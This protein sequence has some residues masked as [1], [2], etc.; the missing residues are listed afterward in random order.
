MIFNYLE[1]ER[2]HRT[3]PQSDTYQDEVRTLF[4]SGL[5]SDVKQRELHL[6]F[7]A[8][9]GKYNF[10]F[11]RINTVISLSVVLIHYPIRRLMLRDSSWN[12]PLAIASFF[13]VTRWNFRSFLA[14][15]YGWCPVLSI[16]YW[17]RIWS[18]DDSISEIVRWY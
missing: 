5:P 18:I 17:S 14:Q 16:Q 2:D 9:K 8:Y 11:L 15:R 12:I 3:S 1:T 13:P 7:R 10:P 6:L 4:V